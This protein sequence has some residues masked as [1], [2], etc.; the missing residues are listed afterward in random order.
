MIL[1]PAFHVEPWA[2]HETELHLDLLAQSESLFALSNGHIGLRG[3]LDEGEPCGLPGTYLNGFYELRPLPYAES[4]YGSPESSQTLVNVTNGKLIRL[5]VDDEPFDVRYGVLRNHDRLLDF[6]AGTL[7]RTAEWT[8]PAG[9]T[10]RVTSHRFVS[11]THRSIVGIGYELEPLDGPANIVVQSELVANEQLPSVAGDPRVAGALESPLQSEE[12]LSRE[13]ETVLIHRTRSS[14]LR[15]AAA[16]DHFISGTSKVHIATDTSPDSARVV[17]T[18]VLEPGQRLRLVKLVAYGWSLERTVPALRDQVAAALAAARQAGWDGLLA[19]QRRYLDDFWARADVELSG[20]SELQQAV[21]FA[22]FHVLQAGARAERRAIPAKGLT[23]TGYD[24]HSFWDTEMFVLPVLTYTIPTAAADTLCWRHSTI[25]AAQQRAHELGLAGSAF[26]WR[27]IHGEECSG[28]WPAGTAA[29]HVNADIADAVI[30]HVNATGDETIERDIGVDILVQT[31]RLWRSLG[32]HDLQGRFRIDGVT[33]PDEYSALADNNVYTNLMA[34]RNLVGAAGVCE[35]HQDK[36]RELGVTPEEVADWR[37]AADLIFIPYDQRLGVHPQAEGF[38]DHEMW[39]FAEMKP[40]Q[41]PLMLHFHYFDLYR[42]QVVKQP[43][44]VLAMQLCGDA[45][46]DEQKARNFDYYERITVRDSSLSACTQA[47]LAAEVGHLRL[48]LDYAAEAA[49]MDLHDLGHNVRDGLHIASLAGTWIALVNG[50]GGMRDHAGVL[51]F[52]PR[53][54]DGLTSLSFS[55]VRRKLCLHVE[56]T[57]RAATYRLTRGQ[58]ALQIMHHG[59]PLT[60]NGS[61]PI[62]RPIPAPVLRVPPAQPPGRE[63]RRRSHGGV[64]R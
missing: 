45:F 7:R 16:M 23:G 60:L 9:R 51:S 49:L 46:T 59:E 55:I 1:H 32:H 8:S 35:R 50:F 25:S 37:A 41:Y 39:N 6:R 17:V 31:A 61:D 34:A 14:G 33:G 11:F 18:D 36:A 20:D 28:Y 12:H 22:L 38:T 29:F 19:D 58:G 40:D 42:K 13:T 24:G 21:R 47:V 3:N 10:M 44:L 56:V 5:L 54:P 15:M 26:P 62:E 27:T 2:L 43:D 52:A 64:S 4:Q 48:A 63:P 53:L 30:R 57:T